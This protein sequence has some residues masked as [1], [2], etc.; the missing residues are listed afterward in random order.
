[1]CPLCLASPDVLPERTGWQDYFNLSVNHGYDRIFIEIVTT[2]CKISRQSNQDCME[3]CEASQWS[4]VQCK[5]SSL[6][7]WNWLEV[8]MTSNNLIIITMLRYLTN[9]N[10]IADLETL[11]PHF[12]QPVLPS[13]GG[14][15]LWGRKVAVA[16]TDCQR[17]LILDHNPVNT[18]MSTKWNATKHSY[19]KLPIANHC[20]NP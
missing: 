2:T 11:E 6:A 16:I 20:S 15:C 4:S 14:A 1:M 17:K 3:R 9:L 7:W 8:I 12:H 18:F 10:T 5:Y 13:P 19:P